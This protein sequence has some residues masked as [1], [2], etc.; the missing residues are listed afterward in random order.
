MAPVD[1][2]LSEGQELLHVGPV[3]SVSNSCGL[4]QTS[5]ATFPPTVGDDRDCGYYEWKLLESFACAM[6]QTHQGGKESQEPLHLRVAMAIR[7]LGMEEPI[8]PCRL[9]TWNQVHTSFKEAEL[10]P[11]FSSVPH[12]L[13]FLWGQENWT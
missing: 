2:M 8:C 3:F 10:G 12:F 5:Q 4:S 11:N 1:V 7:E 13:T 6:V 9:A